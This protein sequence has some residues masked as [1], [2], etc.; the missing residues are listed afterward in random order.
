MSEPGSLRRKGKATWRP[1]SLLVALWWAF[2]GLRYFLAE[3]RMTECELLGYKIAD[4]CV[5][6]AMHSRDG[7]LIWALGL[8]LLITIGLFV[9]FWVL[10]ERYGPPEGR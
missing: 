5:R 7:A 10:R 1:A 6:D 4:S 2:C 9:I 3:R 8:P